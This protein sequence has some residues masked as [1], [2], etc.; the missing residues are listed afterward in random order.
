MKLNS[1]S[2]ILDLLHL[3]IGYFGYLVAIRKLTTPEVVRPCAPVAVLVVNR[4]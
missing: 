4:V 1:C 3:C 2:L